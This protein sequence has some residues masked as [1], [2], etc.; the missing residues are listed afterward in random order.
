M[1]VWQASRPEVCPAAHVGTFVVRA[2]WYPKWHKLVAQTDISPG[3]RVMVVA[4]SRPDGLARSTALPAVISLNEQHSVLQLDIESSNVSVRV[5]V[6]S[7]LV[8][9]NTLQARTT[10]ACQIILRAWPARFIRY[11]A[12]DARRPCRSKYG[13]QLVTMG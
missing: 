3:V 9:L 1:T 8:L 6:T 10:P 7:L 11:G 2:V 5:R 13:I 12:H 4:T